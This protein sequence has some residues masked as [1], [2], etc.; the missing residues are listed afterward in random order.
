MGILAGLPS[1]LE[2]RTGRHAGEIEA[3]VAL[4]VLGLELT[5]QLLL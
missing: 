4:E 5:P 2:P 1:L 3:V